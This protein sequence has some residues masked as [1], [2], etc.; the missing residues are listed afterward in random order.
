MQFKSY[1]AETEDALKYLP[2][3]STVYL[4]DMFFMFLK[5]TGQ[6]DYK[7][8]PQSC[9]AYDGGIA[10][11]NSA[12]PN[13]SLWSY[14]SCVSEIARK[15]HLMHGFE[16]IND[17]II[18]AELF[19]FHFVDD[20]DISV[21]CEVMICNKADNSPMCTLKQNGCGR[22]KLNRRAKR[23]TNKYVK[24]VKK[25]KVVNRRQQYTKNSAMKH[26]QNSLMVLI[27]A[28]VYGV[29]FILP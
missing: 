3:I 11:T 7:I 10:V 6:Q 9:A 5:Y 20:A 1:R 29:E 19:G 4:G 28:V 25:L 24:A 17:K 23:T 15:Y 26:R 13:V 14:D 22:E 18:F 21:E 27:V 16:K 8:V 12:K 2:D